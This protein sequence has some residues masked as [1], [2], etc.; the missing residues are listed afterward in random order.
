MISLEKSYFSNKSITVLKVAS[1]AASWVILAFLVKNYYPS[2]AFFS[3]AILM[4]MM[5]SFIKSMSRPKGRLCEHFLILNHYQDVVSWS[6]IVNVRLKG[7][8]FTFD[9][10]KDTSWRE[11]YDVSLSY[12]LKKEELLDDIKALCEA[13][14]I[15]FE[16]QIDQTDLLPFS[17]Q[18]R[19]GEAIK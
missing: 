3:G 1:I 9:I 11:K 13:K 19:E 18:E 16:F 10:R 17:G 14:N 15:P 8:T 6:N 4:Q 12:I 5:M 7:D 2:L